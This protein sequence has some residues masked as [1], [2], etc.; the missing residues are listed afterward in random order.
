MNA[1]RIKHNGRHKILHI[2]E[3]W[4]KKVQ[5]CAIDAREEL[6]EELMVVSTT[7]PA[8]VFLYSTSWE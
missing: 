4:N 1:I 8:E 5:E 7:K 3:E 2:N 6:Y